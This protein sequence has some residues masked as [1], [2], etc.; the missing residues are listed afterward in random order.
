MDCTNYTTNITVMQ[1][2]DGVEY[3]LYRKLLKCFA[4]ACLT[5]TLEAALLMFAFRLSSVQPSMEVIIMMGSLFGAGFVVTFLPVV[6]YRMKMG[7]IERGVGVLP[8]Y[9][10]VFEQ[11]ASSSWYRGVKFVVKVPYS[12]GKTVKTR[13]AFLLRK[14][15]RT[16]LARMI[17]PAFYADDFRGKEVLVMYNPKR[18]KMYVLDF[19][20]NFSLPTEIE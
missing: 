7:A 14:P 18:N 13:V 1:V 16:S 9:K 2:M 3:T 17:V 20:K 10:V 4:L 8:V 11:T 6:A 15:K 19:A 12:G 5:L